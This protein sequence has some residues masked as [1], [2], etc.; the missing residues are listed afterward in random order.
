MVGPLFKFVPEKLALACFS[1]LGS[2]VIIPQLQ[3]TAWFQIGNE[4]LRMNLRLALPVF[5]V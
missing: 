5:G 2:Q 3:S 4:S 1:A